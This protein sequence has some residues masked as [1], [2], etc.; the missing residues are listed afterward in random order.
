MA[1]TSAA[2]GK[3][4]S[5]ACPAATTG[6]ADRIAAAQ[7]AAS[8][9]AILRSSGNQADVAADGH[10]RR[11]RGAGPGTRR[12]AERLGLSGAC[13]WLDAKAANEIGPLGGN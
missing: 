7:P 13:N 3:T 2:T 6:A 5:R 12:F 11:S 9:T 1:T 8:P 10:L 4:P